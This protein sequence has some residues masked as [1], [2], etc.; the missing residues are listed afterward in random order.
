MASFGFSEGDAK[1]IGRVVRQVERGPDKIRLGG[2]NDQGATPGV[3]LMLGTHGTA[4]WAKQSTKTI[5]IYGGTPGTNGIPTASA[6][7]V[8]ANNIFATLAANTANTARWVAVSC[9][10]FGWYVIAA[11]CE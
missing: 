7:T 1:R 4:E 10:G 3:R 8:V 11:E 2:P 9:N 5:T 6:Y